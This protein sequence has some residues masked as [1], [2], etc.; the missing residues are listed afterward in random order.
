MIID[1]GYWTRILK[2]ILLFTISL[3]LIFLSFKLAIFYTPFLI[4]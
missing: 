1:V 2:N 3:V 4:L